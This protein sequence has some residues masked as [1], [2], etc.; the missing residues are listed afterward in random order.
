MGEGGGKLSG[1][2]NPSVGII[3]SWQGIL[4]LSLRTAIIVSGTLSKFMGLSIKLCV[5]YCG[6]EIYACSYGFV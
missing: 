1:I 4:E 2:V 3:K 5:C 6:A